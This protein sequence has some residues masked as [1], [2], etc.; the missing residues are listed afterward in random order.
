MGDPPLQLPFNFHFSAS[1]FC[2][3]ASEYEAGFRPIPLRLSA[4]R[5]GDASG[6]RSH[7]PVLAAIG[8]A[9]THIRSIGISPRGRPLDQR[10]LEHVHLRRGIEPELKGA[11]GVWYEFISRHSPC[12]SAVRPRKHRFSQQG[13]VLLTTLPMWLDSSPGS[14]KIPKSTHRETRL[15]V[16]ERTLNRSPEIYR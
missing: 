10:K 15:H 1:I 14:P 12:L 8:G 16:H 5:T 11:A 4:C 6:L 3:P 13:T 9:T 2:P 7:G